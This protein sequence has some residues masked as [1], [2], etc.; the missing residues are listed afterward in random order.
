MVS[1]LVQRLPS[2]LVSGGGFL[3]QDGDAA[4]LARVA[5]AIE[6][7]VRSHG[8]GVLRERASA[9]LSLDR[10]HALL[11]A[12]LLIVDLSSSLREPVRD[13][14]TRRAET[15]RFTIAI[16]RP[17]RQRPAESAARPLP[18]APSQ[19]DHTCESLTASRS[20]S[21]RASPHSG[22]HF[23]ESI[24][25]RSSFRPAKSVPTRRSRCSPLGRSRSDVGAPCRFTTS[26]GCSGMRQR[27]VLHALRRLSDAGAIVWHDEAGR[28]VV[29]VEVVGET[30]GRPAPLRPRGHPSVLDACTPHPLV[31]AGAPAR[32]PSG[33]PRL[34]VPPKPRATRRP[35]TSSPRLRPRACLPAA[36]AVA[37]TPRPPAP[38]TSASRH[39]RRRPAISPSSTPDRRPRSSVDS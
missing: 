12:P 23:S 39:S 7:A 26:A 28:G 14:L 5:A 22:C 24:S 32:R 33:V 20:S 34:P 19:L 29:A 8:V 31:R 27:G 17:P 38:Q 16:W 15:A 6:D 3:L 21:R 30:P 37:R 36:L 18:T 2:L 11:A 9:G 13:V 25:G 1:A 10:R 35:H 4:R